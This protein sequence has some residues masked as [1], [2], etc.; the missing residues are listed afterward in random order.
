MSQKGFNINQAP[1][2]AKKGRFPAPEIVKK[3]ERYFMSQ[4]DETEAIS[5]KV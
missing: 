5:G 1:E 3:L 2:I 4:I